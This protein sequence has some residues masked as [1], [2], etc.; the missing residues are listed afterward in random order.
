[1]AEL[2]K[3]LLVR[4]LR[5]AR[6]KVRLAKGKC[7]GAKRYG[8][9]KEQERA[10]LRRIRAMRRTKRGGHKGMTLQAIAD[11]L[12]AESIPTKRGKKWAPAQLHYLLKPRETKIML[13]DLTRGQVIPEMV[14]VE[15]SILEIELALR[16]TGE[17]KI[18][19]LEAMVARL[20]TIVSTLEKKYGN[21]N[22]SD[23]EFEE[24]Y[25]ARELLEQVSDELIRLYDEAD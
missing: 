6:E 5:K 11:R 19:N 2:E 21:M 14:G 9:D 15:V 16:A 25:E 24:Y 3:M 22:I 18:R 1:M 12:N 13:S 20:E 4:R 8:E 23:E 17:E 7:E 10:V